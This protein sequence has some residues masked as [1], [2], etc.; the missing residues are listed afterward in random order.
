MRSFCSCHRPFFFPHPGQG[1]SDHFGGLEPEV[2]C[3][4]CD[5]AWVSSSWSV[6]LGWVF[7]DPRTLVTLGGGARACL[8]SSPLHVELLA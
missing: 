2:V 7:C 6:G 8:A 4:V 5:G 1:P 3:L